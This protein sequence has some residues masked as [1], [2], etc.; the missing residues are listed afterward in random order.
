MEAPS[1]GAPFNT[2]IS[3][4][5]IVTL[6]IVTVVNVPIPALTV[7]VVIKLLLLKSI[8]PL[9]DTIDPVVKVKFLIVPIPTVLKF[10]PTVRSFPIVRLVFGS[11][12]ESL[13]AWAGLTHANVPF[14]SS[15]FNIY[16]EAGLFVGNV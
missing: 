10:L 5:S 12:N 4:T 11:D 13:I 15:A 8:A 14:A 3:F 16:F 6:P 9:A 1:N 7:P 2:L